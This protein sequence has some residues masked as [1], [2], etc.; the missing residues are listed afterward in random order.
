M[1]G[2]FTRDFRINA[3]TQLKESIDEAQNDNYYF[4]IGRV[5]PWVNE[6]EPPAT[7]DTV[8]ALYDNW[9]EIL[10]FKKVVPSEAS[11]VIPR[12]NWTTGTVYQE[13]ND[14]LPDLQ[15]TN[16]YVMTEDFNVYKCISNGNGAPSTIKP[17][18]TGVNIF[19]TADGYKWKFM[20][21]IGATD[22]IRFL[23]TSFIPV[24]RIA[25]DDGSLQWNVQNNAVNGALHH[26]DVISGGSNYIFHSGTLTS[27]TNTTVMQLELG[28]NTFNNSYKNSAIYIVSGPGAGQVRKITDYVGG[29]TRTIT[30]DQPFS[31]APTNASVY[32]VSPAVN[33][34]G[35]GTG[36]S[37]YTTVSGGVV[38]EIT[39]V[40]MG[41]N[42]TVA[43]IVLI[44]NSGTGAT[45]RTFIPPVGGHGKDPVSELGGSN[46]MFN[47]VLSADEGGNFTVSN[48]YRT[49]G[50]VQNPTLNGSSTLATSDSYDQ[51]VKL[52]VTG[53]SAQYIPDE[54]LVGLTS[55]ATA[56]VVDFTANNKIRV[57]QTSTINFT[58]GEIV[59]GS[60]SLANSS[61]VS[62]TPRTIQPYSG[63]LLYFENRSPI[64]RGE[65]QKELI[66]ITIR[67]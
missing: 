25:S 21:Q 54:P 42:Y 30:V 3:A 23:T 13:Y 10:A 37:A 56:K 48:E 32:Y 28:A 6:A 45:A 31:P 52:N 7:Q 64:A 36:A 50:L 34:N 59:S 57:I 43:D 15:T 19:N 2:T 67:F 5:T 24:K 4:F 46:I 27:V 26:Y 16:F 47:I 51:T 14:K 60:I 22:A 62:V 18:G 49:I 63:K 40:T 35:D 53:H 33:I 20:Y 1:A 11:Y 8:G 55:G 58:T 44:S 9:K 39:P 17:S 61:I 66:K 29:P 41:A 12:Y 38:T 65:D